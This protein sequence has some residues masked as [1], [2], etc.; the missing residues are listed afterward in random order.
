VLAVTQ[1]APAF[2]ALF[3]WELAQPPYWFLLVFA[4]AAYAAHGLRLLREQQQRSQHAKG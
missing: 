1:R 3:V 2:A 4:V